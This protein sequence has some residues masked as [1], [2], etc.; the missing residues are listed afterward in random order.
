MID[1]QL[2]EKMDGKHIAEYIRMTYKTVDARNN[3]QGYMDYISQMFG[4]DCK[5]MYDNG[6]DLPWSYSILVYPRYKSQFELIA[7]MT[8]TSRKDRTLILNFIHYIGDGTHT[9]LRLKPYLSKYKTRS[10]AEKYITNASQISQRFNQ[11]LLEFYEKRINKEKLGP[12][13]NRKRAW[14]F[15]LY[16]ES[17]IEKE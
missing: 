3:I 8:E 6:N 12:M 5:L 2:I 14:V 7:R 11:G 1:N 10:I 17:L 13:N 9:E 4:V 15:I 16:L